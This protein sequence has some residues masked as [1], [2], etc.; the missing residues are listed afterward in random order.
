MAGSQEQYDNSIGRSKGEF[1]PP[2]LLSPTAESS[3]LGQQPQYLA[4]TSHNTK[5]AF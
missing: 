5:A 1:Q 2:T 3:F 4:D